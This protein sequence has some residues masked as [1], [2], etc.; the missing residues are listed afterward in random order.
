LQDPFLSE[1][2]GLVVRFDFPRNVWKFT[3]VSRPAIYH[4][5]LEF[6]ARI[7]ATVGVNLRAGLTLSALAA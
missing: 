6:S 3:R 4:N 7:L 5:I 2:D 1:A